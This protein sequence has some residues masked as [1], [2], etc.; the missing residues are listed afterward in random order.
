[1]DVHPENNYVVAGMADGLV[2]IVKRLKK[3][4]FEIDIV[5]AL[6]RVFSGFSIKKIDHIGIGY[7]KYNMG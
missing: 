2:Q 3:V 4:C 1:M 5:H 7:F 6:I